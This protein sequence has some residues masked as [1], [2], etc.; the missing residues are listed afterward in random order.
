M[1]FSENGTGGFAF[2]FQHQPVTLA[3]QSCLSYLAVF[4]YIHYFLEV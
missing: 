3:E 1:L 4:C 2:C